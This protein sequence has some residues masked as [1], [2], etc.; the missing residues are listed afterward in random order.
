MLYCCTY[1]Y[2]EALKNEKKSWKQRLK[3]SLI[4]LGL[5]I[6]LISV[7]AFI[8]VTI[9]PNNLSEFQTQI[10]TG[11]YYTGRITSARPAST[12]SQGSQTGL[13]Q[14]QQ[15]VRGVVEG[16]PFAGQNFSTTYTYLSNTANS[17][18]LATGDKVI[19]SQS[20]GE[21]G[22]QT[23]FINGKYRLDN[24]LWIFGFFV[25]LAVIFAGVKG[26]SSLLGMLFSLSVLVL[27]TIPYILT[28]MN[29]ILVSIVSV[30]IIACISLYVAHGFNRRT[31]VALVGTIL[32]TM[33]AIIFSFLA[34]RFM[35]LS[36]V[37]DENDLYLQN[38]P[39]LA[40]VNL[41]G[42]LLCGIIIGTLGILD[43]ITTAQVAVVEELVKVDWRMSWQKVFWKAMSVGREH[44]VSLINT[45]VL[46]YVSTSLPLIITFFVY[47]YEPLWVWLNRDAII[48]E[49]VRT[50]SGSVALLVAVPIATLV[51]SL[52]FTYIHNQKPE[53]QFREKQNF[54]FKV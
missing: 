9:Q 45:L 10:N 51:A 30:F 33:F 17:Y 47:R 39:Q 26:I 6:G 5:S 21:N 2:N 25:I 23:L 11:Q 19:L 27:F 41:Q 1:H 16:G 34:V 44:I 29:P 50:L 22:E 31:T 36:G 53:K 20:E 13:Q 48:Q 3:E 24:L 7:V 28:G 8:L 54:S 4:Q 12:V 14:A 35:N 52:Y 18:E 32:T 40:N 46:A 15:E 38:I 42:L 37:A 43:D 49:I